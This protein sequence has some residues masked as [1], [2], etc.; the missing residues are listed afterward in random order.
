MKCL[1]MNSEVQLESGETLLGSPS[2][3]RVCGYIIF[4]NK[5][6][7]S[8]LGRKALDIVT[9]RD[10]G[11]LSVF[12]E[13]GKYR[14]LCGYGN[15][16]R[17]GGVEAFSYFTASDMTESRASVQVDIFSKN[18]LVKENNRRKQYGLRVLPFD[19]SMKSNN[20]LY[21]AYLLNDFTNAGEDSW[22]HGVEAERDLEK[23]KITA[24]S[25]INDIVKKLNSKGI[26]CS[27]KEMKCSNDIQMLCVVRKR[28]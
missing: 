13:E 28:F 6:F 17:H 12:D 8:Q 11:Y 4:E 20:S 24:Y 9:E 21:V 27:F 1:A 3:Y 5:D 25:D 18:E 23:S 7:P 16:N 10:E 19:K 15:M 14:R 26:K 22:L 2:Y